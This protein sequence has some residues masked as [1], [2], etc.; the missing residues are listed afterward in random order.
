MIHEEHHLHLQVVKLRHSTVRLQPGSIDAAADT[1]FY[2]A[3]SC[4][5]AQVPPQLTF[6]GWK[7]LNCKASEKEKYMPEVCKLHWKKF[8]LILA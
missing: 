5:F 8:S 2:G 3:G 1:C 6:L 7:Q 4:T